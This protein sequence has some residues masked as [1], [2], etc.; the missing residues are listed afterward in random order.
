MAA[1]VKYI[2]NKNNS[3]TSNENVAE[4][5]LQESLLHF[6]KNEVFH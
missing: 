3:N 2:R 1:S 6:T 4:L 5:C